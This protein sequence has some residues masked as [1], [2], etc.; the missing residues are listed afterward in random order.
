MLEDTQLELEDRVSRSFLAPCAGDNFGTQD[1][2]KAA[3]AR[4][5][6][7]YH[8]QPFGLPRVSRSLVSFED[9]QYEERVLEST[10]TRTKN[11]LSQLKGAEPEMATV[12]RNN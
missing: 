9:L 1:Q 4:G 5:N 10:L 11:N 8:N 7:T 3:S 12:Q 6:N 2:G